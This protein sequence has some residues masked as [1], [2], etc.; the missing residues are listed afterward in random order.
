[1]RCRA[2]L[3]AT[4]DF[5]HFLYQIVGGKRLRQECGAI[6]GNPLAQQ[7]V[8]RVSR[9]KQGANSR[10][11]LFDINRLRWSKE[12]CDLFKVPIEILP[13]VRPSAGDF[14]KTVP[15]SDGRR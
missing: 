5:A 8:F 6:G 14:G 4:N 7:H 13:E 9:Y 10:T 11:L 1:M 2:S 15:S 3:T 12:L